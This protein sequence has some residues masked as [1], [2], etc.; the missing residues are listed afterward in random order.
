MP[1]NTVNG[2]NG[3]K[4]VKDIK[5]IISVN[6]LNGTNS[7]NGIN[8]HSSPT[9]TSKFLPF[10]HL[11]DGFTRNGK[12]A[13][14]KYSSTLTNHHDAPGAKVR[15]NRVSSRGKDT[16]LSYRLCFMQLAFQTKIL[17]RM[18]HMSVSLLYGGKGILAICIVSA[19]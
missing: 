6:G 2:A 5:T 10:K 8:G 1:T 11:P 18:H 15:D 16:H 14:N 12:L 9:K 17:C 19:L 4:D 13:L 3:V 7:I